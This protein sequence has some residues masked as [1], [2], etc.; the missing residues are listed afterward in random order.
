[1]WKTKSFYLLA[2]SV[3]FLSVSSCNNHEISW[4]DKAAWKK[5]IM[6]CEGYRKSL[7]PVLEK[8]K[9]ELLNQKDVFFFHTLGK[10]NRVSYSERGKKTFHYF[11]TPGAQCKGGSGIIESLTIEF[12]ALGT[13]R[14]IYL[15]PL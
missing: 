15:K 12:E 10:A 3:V 8:H 11:L 1:M 7:I 5:D 9:D 4:I 13:A 14:V 6:G 2:I